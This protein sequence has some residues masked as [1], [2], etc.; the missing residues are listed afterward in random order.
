MAQQ[1]IER[2]SGGRFKLNTGTHVDNHPTKT[3]KFKETIGK[4]APSGQVYQEEVIREVPVERVLYA[5][6]PEAQDFVSLQDLDKLD[7]PGMR[8]KF[9]RLSDGQPTESPF[10]NKPAPG[11]LTEE[12]ERRMARLKAADP[13]APLP[14]ANQP[15]VQQVP[16]QAQLVAAPKLETMTIEELQQFTKDMIADEKLDAGD[17]KKLFEKHRNDR[18]PIV[19]ALKAQLGI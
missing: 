7:T 10:L 6:T 11:E 2:K 4:L 16:S 3:R 14:P 9:T 18:G 12:F 19:K 5:G 8:P 13:N 1:T 15:P 17:V